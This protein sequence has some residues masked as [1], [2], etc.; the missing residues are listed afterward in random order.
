MGFCHC[1]GI[2]YCATSRHIYQ[3]ADGAMPSWKE[4]HFCPKETA[5]CGI[6]GLSAVPKP[7]G[8]GE[9]LWF[10][11]LSKVRRLDPADAFKETM[12]LDIPTFLTE[13]LGVKVTFALSAYNELMS[14]TVP[15]TTETLWVFGFECS[16]PAAVVNAHPRIQARVQMRE[17][18]RA[19]FP[20]NA[21]YCIR[22]A[23]GANITYEVA[24]IT[25]PREP[26]LVSTRVTAVS[27]F[28]EDQGKVLYFGGYD[29][30]S[31]PSHNTGWVYRGALAATK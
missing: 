29:C 1:N 22:H 16:H 25:D 18:P 13:K 31:V 20:G 17:T 26:Q 2:F 15:G 4:V 30:N 12:E 6:R 23:Q 27:P 8:S 11:A 10:A 7:G 19:Y 9:V 5:P 28:P 21:R 3:R 14:Y 24:E